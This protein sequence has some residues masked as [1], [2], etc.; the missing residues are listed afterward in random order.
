[1]VVVTLSK[2]NAKNSLKSVKLCLLR[3]ENLS[4]ETDESRGILPE[5]I[6]YRELQW[7]E[8]FK[9]SV[10]VYWINLA[11]FLSM[12]FVFLT[13]SFNLTDNKFSLLTS[14]N[15][16]DHL[17]WLFKFFSNVLQLRTL[18]KFGYCRHYPC[19]CHTTLSVHK[20]EQFLRICNIYSQIEF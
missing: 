4:F 6:F 9:V 13:S 20:N 11:F 7:H 5:V 8:F 10:F 18:T 14:E 19:H 12:S 2:I 16:S 17:F 3:C 15:S 1:M